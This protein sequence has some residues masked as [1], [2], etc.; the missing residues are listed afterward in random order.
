MTD[1]TQ[2]RLLDAAEGVF[3][4]KGFKAASI[5]EICK[6]AGANIAAVNYYF[7]DKEQLYIETVKYA[8]R[9]CT[10]GVPFPEWALGTPAIEKLRDVIRVMVTRM[11]SPQSAAALQL[12][13]REM[14]Q[15]TAACA[16][17]VRDHIRPMADQLGAILAEL[18]PHATEQQ[19]YLVAFSI[20]GQSHFY[21]NHRAVAAMLVGEERFREFDVDLVAGHI[22]S[23][24]LRGLGLDHAVVAGNSPAAAP[25]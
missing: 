16:A 21:R 14:V 8:N 5:R 1:A 25:E 2:Q 15:P 3:A 20:V 13:M 7:G 6:Q 4:E 12:M 23:F 18:L 9:C 10:E 19:R 24:T 22:F 17:V 11:L